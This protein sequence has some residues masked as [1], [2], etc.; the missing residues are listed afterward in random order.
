[1]E[2]CE[3]KRISRLILFLLVFPAVLKAE[4]LSFG[5]GYPYISL[6]Y[7][8]PAVS[9]EGRFV[10]DPGIRVYSGRGY[11][12][13]HQSEKLNGFAGLEVG[14]IKFNTLDTR[15]TGYEGALFVGGEYVVTEKIYLLM[16]F[17]PTL[18]ALRHDTY[19]DIKVSGVEYVVNL[20]FY[21]RFGKPGS[22]AEPANKRAVKSSA[23]GGGAAQK[24]PDWL[25]GKIYNPEVET[26]L[27]RLKSP[28]W[29]E[30]RV[31][32]FELGKIKAAQALNPLLELL[33]DE[34]DKVRGVAAL[35][36]GR[37]G[38]QQALYPL[39]ERLK[40]GSAYVRASAAK[41]LG[42]LGDRHA[43]NALEGALKDPSK[44][45]R[46]AAGKAL[47]KTGAATQP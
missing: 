3:M 22:K 43:G 26:W 25:A 4:N 1:M 32:A 16:D 33:N 2:Q 19:R 28:D 15:G 23:A 20:G 31:A 9:A 41:G 42:Y 18:I 45:V 37:I 21:Y 35:A 44:E 13:F 17:A 10:S 40:D 36:L 46:K 5:L 12:N 24:E 7:D 29:Q 38:G 11:W 14:Y 39:M 47:E 27:S 30:R 6:K 8:L 34:N